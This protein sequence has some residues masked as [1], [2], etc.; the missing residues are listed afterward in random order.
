MASADFNSSRPAPVN[1]L[2]ATIGDRV[3]VEKRSAHIVFHFQPH[4]F[5]R[6]R[7][8]RIGF[9][10]HGDAA[11]NRKQAADIEVFASLRL[12][13]LIGGDYE[14][15]QVDAADA[16]KHVAHKTLV[17]GDVDET[18]AKPAAI[19]GGKFEV[20]KS[21]VDGDAAP[22]FFFEAVGI[23]AGQGFHQRRFAVIDMS[24]GADDD[25]LHLRQYRRACGADSS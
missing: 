14:Q 22:L 9:C 3:G 5:E 7:I 18:Q 11:A 10:E 21:D 6:L 17:A 23:N 15:H 4:D 2:T 16:R 19:G 13:P 24:G 12:D 25:G 20:G 8:H 1:E